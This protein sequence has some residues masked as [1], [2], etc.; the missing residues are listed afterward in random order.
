MSL[1]KP[2]AEIRKSLHQ[3][4][5]ISGE[6]VKTAETIAALLRKFE[7]V[8]LTTNIGG[9]GLIAE[10]KFGP[11]PTIAFRAELDGL[12]ILEKGN[13]AHLSKVEGKSH[14]CGHDGHMSILLDLF[15]KLHQSKLDKGTIILIFQPAEET[16]QGARAMV[17]S[18]AF[19]NTQIDFCYA[20]HNVPGFQKG[21]VLGCDGPFAC[22]SVGV[23]FIIQGKTAHAAHPENAQN[24]LA[25]ATQIMYRIS[26]LPNDSAVKGF[27]LTTPIALNSGD[28]NFGTSPADAV[29]M[30]TLRAASTRDI[31]FMMD[32]AKDVA[33]SVD[34]NTGVQ[35]TTSFHEYFPATEN[36]SHLGELTQACKDFG[37]DFK[38][39]NQPFRWSED[40]AHFTQVFPAAMFGLGSG[41][42][43]PA[44]HAPNYDFPD[45]ITGVGSGVFLELYKKHCL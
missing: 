42:D 29:L 41:E 32:A 25:A 3:L 19:K 11:G 45:E 28:E 5:E 13:H 10:K 36:H 4:P 17:E 7:A 6:E 40:F 18:G 37:A 22:A 1:N 20:L 27:A 34:S 44:L 31:E 39:L 15:E 43:S 2:I 38:K 35:T 26:G 14:A 30:M 12:P 8:K 33:K 16:G 9:N 24:P 21:L 23:R